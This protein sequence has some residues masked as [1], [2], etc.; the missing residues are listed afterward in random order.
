MKKFLI[1]FSIVFINNLQAQFFRPKVIDSIKVEIYKSILFSKELRNTRDA[2]LVS[3]QT[4]NTKIDVQ[5]GYMSFIRS[6]EKVR[7]STSV[8]KLKSLLP[9]S[10]YIFEETETDK[11]EDRGA[12][13]AAKFDFQDSK[14]ALFYKY[15]YT[16]IRI[17]EPLTKW[18]NLFLYFHAIENGMP[19][20]IIPVLCV[21][22]KRDTEV[23]R[24]YYLYKTTFSVEGKIE[25]VEVVN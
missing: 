9:N 15:T 6:I 1:L 11:L 19:Y 20:E 25:S 10:Y 5:R 22:I 4:I 13:I 17:Y 12:M 23:S 24:K 14:K 2:Y 7:D 18:T 3:I 16:Y 8:N 21:D